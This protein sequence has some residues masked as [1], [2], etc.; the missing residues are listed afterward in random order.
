[1]NPMTANNTE[2]EVKKLSEEWAAAELRGDTA[3]LERTLANDF[4]GIGPRGFMLT[5]EEWLQRITSGALKYDRFDWGEVKVRVYRDA[6]IVIG[7]QAQKAR[8]QDQPIEGEFRTML[9]FVRQQGRWLL[10]G[11]QLSPIAGPIPGM[12]STP[13]GTAA[14]SPGR[15]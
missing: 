1:M 9:V 10:A 11:L 15:R 12:P 4:V 14:S 7:R 13:P 5:K 6:A 8:Y 3:F 2:Q